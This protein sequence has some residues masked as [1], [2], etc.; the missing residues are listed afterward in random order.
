MLVPDA[1]SGVADV[2][3]WYD[4]ATQCFGIEVVVQNRMWGRL[5]GYRGHFQVEWRTVDAGVAETL[6]PQRTEQRE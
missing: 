4:D 2:C 6:L 3:E 1:L 5:F